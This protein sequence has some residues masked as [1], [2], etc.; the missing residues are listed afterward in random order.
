MLYF[1]ALF[2]VTM[3]SRI[4]HMIKYKYLPF[5][6][7]KKVRAGLVV[8]ALAGVAAGGWGDAAGRRVR[9]EQ[10]KKTSVETS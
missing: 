3:K 1:L 5:T 4:K 10:P 8:A 9:Q 6:S 2:F 7:G